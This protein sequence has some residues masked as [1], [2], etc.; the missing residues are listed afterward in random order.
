MTRRTL[1]LAYH[2]LG[3]FPRALDPD[4]LMLAPDRFREQLESLKRRRYR[5]VTLAE[6][7]AQLDG[8]TPPTGLCALTFDDGTLDNLEVLAPLLTELG[9][10]ATVFACPGLLG[11]EHFAMPPDAGVRLMNAEELRALASSPLIEIG[12]HTNT[13]AELAHATAEEA[14]RDM[15]S[16]KVALEDLLE[17]PISFFAYPKCTYSAAC[18]PSAERA[19]YS[20]AVTCGDRGGWL[21]FELA[22]EAIDSLDR[23]VSF[24]LKSRGLYLPLRNSPAGKLGRALVRPLRHPRS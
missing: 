6:L 19:G 23:R 22:R 20:A 12:S 17:R 2:G 4:N 1:V 13:H 18:P 15:K 8:A 10:P 16:S 7:A 24:A 9:V 21:R 3:T 5:F 14:Y 11:A